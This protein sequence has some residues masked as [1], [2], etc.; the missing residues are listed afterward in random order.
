LLWQHFIKTKKKISLCLFLAADHVISEQ[1][2]FE[3]SVI[4]AIDLA[5]SVN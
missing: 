3:R 4:D 1:S 2:I 5:S